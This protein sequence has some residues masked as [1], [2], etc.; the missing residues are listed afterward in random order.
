VSSNTRSLPSVGDTFGFRLENGLYGCCRV[1]R[2]LKENPN[3]KS[4][5]D[6]V[7]VAC[8]EWIGESTPKISE[9]DLMP[10]LQLTHHKWDR[11]CINWLTSPVESPFVY[12]GKTD[13]SDSELTRKC[14]STVRWS[15]LPIQR[16]SQ[17]VWDN[18]P[19]EI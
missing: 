19:N 7:L 4:S 15:F 12:I 2:F 17:W 6:A 9:I 16:L 5:C 14:D 3:D 13:P 18:N 11:P 1:I 10:I 8:C